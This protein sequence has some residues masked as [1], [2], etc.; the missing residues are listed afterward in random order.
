LQANFESSEYRPYASGLK[1]AS[2]VLAMTGWGVSFNQNSN[3]EITCIRFA[4]F[5]KSF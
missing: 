5:F 3:L 2:A 1:F 4:G